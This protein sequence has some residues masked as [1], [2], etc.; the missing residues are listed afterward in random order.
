MNGNPATTTPTSSTTPTAL[1]SGQKKKTKFDS[2]LRR[3]QANIAYLLA[4][5]QGKAIPPFPA[6]IEAPSDAWLKEVDDGESGDGNAD[7]LKEAYAKLKA[8]WPNYKGP[9]RPQQQLSGGQAQLSKQGQQ[10]PAQTEV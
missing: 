7:E 2:Y 5:S 1:P 10:A 9:P 8:L 4:I 3:L 6:A